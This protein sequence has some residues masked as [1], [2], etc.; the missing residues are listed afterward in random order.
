[1]SFHYDVVKEKKEGNF[2]LKNS[3]ETPSF[4]IQYFT[5]VEQIKKYF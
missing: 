2:T 4:F 3:R 5:K 1:M